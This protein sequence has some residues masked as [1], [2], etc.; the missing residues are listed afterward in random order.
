MGSLTRNAGRGRS[1][2]A[3]PEARHRRCQAQGEQVPGAQRKPVLADMANLVGE[4]SP[5]PWSGRYPA[6]LSYASL[7]A[8]D[9]DLRWLRATAK[10]SI[11][12]NAP[13]RCRYARSH[14]DEAKRETNRGTASRVRRQTCG[15]IPRRAIGMGLVS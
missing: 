9:P 5:E 6:V 4:P 12:R 13:S 1:A 15:V 11:N 2:E 14:Y 8:A 3:T 10:R 7:Y